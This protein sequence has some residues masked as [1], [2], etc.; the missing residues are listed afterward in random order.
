MKKDEIKKRGRILGRKCLICFVS[1]F[2][3]VSFVKYKY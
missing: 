2:I 3:F 1:F